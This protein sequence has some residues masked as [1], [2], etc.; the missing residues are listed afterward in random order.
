MPYN[1]PRWQSGDDQRLNIIRRDMSGG[2]NTRVQANSIKESQAV[3]M[4]NIDISVPGQMKKRPGS[5]LIGDD[6]GATKFESLFN[7]VI[8]GTTDLLIGYVGTSIRAWNG[9]GNWAAAYKSDFTINQTDIGI[10]SAKESGNTPDD[11]FLVS[12]GTDNVFRFTSTGVPEDCLNIN[13]SP[14][15][16]TV[17]AW[18]NNRVWSLKNDLL[19]YSD[20]YPSSYAPEPAVINGDSATFTGVANDKLNVTVDSVVYSSI[21]VS[22]SSSIANVVTAINGIA[23][24]TPASVVST[25]LQILSSTQ[26]ATSNVTIA[27]GTGGNGGEAARLFSVEADRTDTGYS[28]W[29]RLTNAFRIPIGDERGIVPTRDLGMVVLGEEAIWALSPTSTPVATDQPV[30][31]VTFVGCVSKQGWASVGDDIFFFAQ[32]GL[33]ELKRTIQDK[34]QTGDSFPLSFALKDAYENIAWAFIANLSMKYFDNKLFI[35]VPTSATTF[36]TWVYYPS[37]NAF[38]II[39]GWKPS[40][41][42]TYKVNGEERFYYGKV[43]DGVVH[44]GWY[45]FTDEGTTTTN[46]TAITMIETT[47]EEDFSQPL[48]QK[49][50]GEVEIE[51]STVGNDNSLLIEARRDGG[52]W[53]TLG[54]VLLESEDAPTLPIDLPFSLSD[55]YVIRNKLHLDSLSAFRTIQFRITNSDVNVEEI[56]IYGINA[57]TFPQEYNNEAQHR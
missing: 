13:N 43:G 9:T 15:L 19:Y 8:Q 50:G 31:L 30:P 12:N 4:T 24:G 2:Q 20:A 37:Y 54:S 11:V 35:S 48:T 7:F 52:S 55:N 34:L 56:K 33:R 16:T 53:E 29:D 42:E 17:M 45:G 10:V 49:V 44:R 3:E 46:G 39:N 14:P 23:S 25:K 41:M 22:A 36:D 51:T 32:D 38:T 26:G 6:I 21:D 1:Q 5:V 40:C 28:P 18:Y 47:R 57:I 27:D